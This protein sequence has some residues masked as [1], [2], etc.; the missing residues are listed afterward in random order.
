MKYRH[1]CSSF[2]LKATFYFLPSSNVYTGAWKSLFLHVI[3][4]LETPWEVF[5]SASRFYFNFCPSAH[6]PSYGY[7]R[8]GEP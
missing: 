6:K 2:D 8:V 1:K 4:K 3:L 5:F 7:Y